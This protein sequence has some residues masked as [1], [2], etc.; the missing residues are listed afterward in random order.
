MALGIALADR[1]DA[2][3][4]TAVLPAALGLALACARRFRLAGAVA[5]ACAAG[6][7]AQA[8]RLGDAR[9]ASAGDA[10]EVVVEGV[11]SRRSAA[12]A[13]R[14]I[15]LD[16]VR[17]AGVARVR[18]YSTQPGDLEEWLPGDTLRARLRIA[19]LCWARNPGDGDPLRRLW[20]AGLA[21]G[22]ALPHPSLAA[23]RAPASAPRVALHRL[24][25]RIGA[26]LGAG[27]DGAGLLR[28][29]ALGDED[30][31]PSEQHEAF[32]RLGLEHA[33]SVSGLHLAWVS[34]AI[35]ALGRS[36]LRRS[37]WLAARCDTRR[38]AL[39]G[40][41]AAAFA[42]AALAG[43][44][45][46]VRRSLL[47]VLAVGI[48]VARR[49]PQRTGASLAAAALWILAEEPDALFQPGA[50][51]SFAAMAAFAWA[52]RRPAAREQRI[53][54]ALRTSATAIAATAPIVAW[55]GGGV[56]SAAL[57][58]NAIALPWLECA[59]LPAALAAAVAAAL[60]LPGAD[61]LIRAAGAIAS[62]TTTALVWLAN[63]LPAL[64]RAAPATAWW[65]ASL[66]LAALGLA[67]RATALRAAVAVALAA[68]LAVAPP[69]PLSPAPPRLVVLDVGQGDAALVQGRGG[70]VLVDAGPARDD[71]DAGERRVVPALRALGVT[72]LDLVIATHAD[73]DHRGGLPAVLRGVPVAELWLPFGAL[74][75]PGFADTLAAARAAGTRVREA[76]RGSPRRMA[77]E[78]VVDPIWPP[79]FGTGSR[80]HRSLVVRIAAPGGLRVLLPGDLD[81]TAEAQLVAL[82]SDAHADVLLLPHHGSRG[83]SSPVFLDAVAPR[84]AIASAPCRSRFGMPHPDVR[85][86]LAERAVPL[87]W[88]GRDGALLLA[89]RGP[90]T[91]HGTG[92]PARCP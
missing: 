70:A 67:A 17:G 72:R 11:V 75:D 52:L 4:W 91:P 32:H 61:A 40:A 24:R 90:P 37:A 12:I 22:G 68:L 53:A 20:R 77:G 34:A 35:Y 73:L 18:V 92:A 54:A 9:A 38:I 66:A 7:H 25:A 48:A 69:A 42:Y 55:H 81:A 2:P 44:A 64:D 41:C 27:G 82:Q 63:Q 62:L 26:A 6:L 80:N 79:R 60:E 13:P 78:L 5:L 71:F 16:G 21:V 58:A 19:P 51:L 83:S 76:G 56:S 86:R 28:G 33:L 85:A 89:L 31:L 88:T 29:L 50:Q 46:P 43:W 65:I 15:E 1:C 84:L 30:A 47:V 36:A 74:G 49:R 87:A 8:V 45:V 14:W 39:A 23:A 10:R 3:P 59:V 57:A